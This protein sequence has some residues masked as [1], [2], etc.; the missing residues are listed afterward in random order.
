MKL[1][2]KKLTIRHY[3]RYIRKQSVHIQHVHAFGFAG[4]ITSLIAAFILYTEYG[5]WHETYRS[6]DALEVVQGSVSGESE[7]R[8]W[9]EFLSEAKARFNEIGT[10]G[11][12]FLEGKETYKKE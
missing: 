4:V 10:E 7:S 11:A 12:T 9:G 1:P 3:I 5:F 2:L 8:S 6:D